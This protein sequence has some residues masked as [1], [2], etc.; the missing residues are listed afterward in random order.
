MCRGRAGS[1]DT[2]MQGVKNLVARGFDHVQ[3]TTVIHPRNISEMPAMYEA[4]GRTGIDSWRLVNVEPIGRAAKDPELMLSDKQYLQMM[5]FI[6]E[7]RFKSPMEVS[8]G[9][10]HYLG[11]ELEREVR[12][13]YFL[14]NA[15]VYCASVMYNGDIGA[16]LDIERRPELVQGNIRRDSF[17]DVWEKGFQI[18]RSDYRKVGKC[19]ECEDYRF[20]GGDSFH[21]WNFDENRPNLCLKGIL[22]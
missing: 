5:D 6:R 15:G 20:C 11:A 14:C 22:F 4:F 16:C 19:A 12:P 10:S 7:Y 17:R 8:F 21:T 13:W 3:I 1:F 2:T 9:C 18:Y